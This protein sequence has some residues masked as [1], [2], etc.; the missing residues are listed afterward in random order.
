MLK[1]TAMV[2][3]MTSI[4]RQVNSLATVLNS[5]N[6]SGYATVMSS[7]AS[8]PVSIMTKKESGF[9][10]IFSVGMRPGK[11]KTTFTVTS[12]TSV[13]VIGE[14]RTIPVSA[15]QFTDSMATDYAVHLYKIT[16]TGSGIEPFES[17]KIFSVFPDPA[18]DWITVL[19]K[20]SGV[21]LIT[22]LS[23]RMVKQANITATRTQMDIS[24]LHPGYFC[25]VNALSK[26]P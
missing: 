19:T 21:I 5:P 25:P 22:E 9:N 11:S 13:S 7:N 16:N 15:G 14:N 26:A 12:G 18:A 10:Y 6:T 8:V 24:F 23:G 1:D 17:S 2:T 3:A 4:N 20:S